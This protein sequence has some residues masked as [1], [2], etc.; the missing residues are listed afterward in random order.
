MECPGSVALIKQLE[1]PPSDDPDYQ[2]EGTAAHEVLEACL[3]SGADAWEH[4]GT[5]A[6]NG[7]EIDAEITNAVQEF[8]DVVRPTFANGAVVLIEQHIHRPEI[9][10]LYYG[11]IDCGVIRDREIE[12]GDFGADRT[13]RDLDVNDYKHGQGIAVD[14]EWNPQLLYYAYGLLA[15]YPGIDGIVTLRIIQPRAFHH[16][17]TIREWKVEADVVRQWAKGT[18]VPAM[19]RTQSDGAPFKDGAW[20]RFCPA[21]LVCPVLTKK[22]E[23]FTAPFKKDLTDEEVGELYTHVASVKHFMKALE[24]AAYSRLSAGKTVP[25]AKLVNKKANRVFKTG[26]AEVFKEQFGDDALT[27]P[28]L[29]SPAEMEKISPTAKKLVSEW[30]YL[31]HTGLTVAREDDDR[32]GVKVET[33]QETFGAAVAALNT[34]D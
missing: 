14:V 2:R 16:A 12:V 10:E 27:Q 6:S 32:L 20:C 5:K 22:F 1:L 8:I 21:K 29:K 18:L 24:E 33:A 3:K 23:D 28:E 13:V 17:G 31:P 11:T 19:V 9:H 25:G 7:V 4:A 15:Q 34:G 26:A 30:A